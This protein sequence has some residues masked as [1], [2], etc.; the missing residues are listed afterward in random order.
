M[1]L[2]CLCRS[3]STAQLELREREQDRGPFLIGGESGGLGMLP[4]LALALDP[5]CK[6]E[7]TAECSRRLC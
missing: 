6:A 4:S 5:V 1:R 3:S 2:R 7:S